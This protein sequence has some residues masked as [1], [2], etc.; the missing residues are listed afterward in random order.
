MVKFGTPPE[1]CTCDGFGLKPQ[2]GNGFYMRHHGRAP[3]DYCPQDKLKEP[4]P[5]ILDEFSISVKNKKRTHA[6]V[7]QFC[8]GNGR[9]SCLRFEDVFS[10]RSACLPSL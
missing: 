8:Y 9:V 3:P 6:Q 5:E 1:I 10:C 7:R 4:T 2:K